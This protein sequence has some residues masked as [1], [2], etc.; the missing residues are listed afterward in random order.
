MAKIAAAAVVLGLL[1]GVATV[2]LRRQPAPAPATSAMTVATAPRL[3]QPVAASMVGLRIAAPGAPSSEAAGL[4]VDGGGLVVT[5][6]LIPVGASVTILTEDHRSLA[7]SVQ[8]SD[9]I[10]GLSLLR[11]E[12]ELPAPAV[13]AAAPQGT[14][15]ATEVWLSS[16][17]SGVERITWSATTL[18]TPD[19]PVVVDQVGLGTMTDASSGATM[20]GS[21]LVA[22]DGSLLGIAAPELGLHHWLPAA[23][24]ESLASSTVAMSSHGCLKIEGRTSAGGV[25]VLSVEPNGPAAGLLEPGDVVTGI[26]TSQLRTISEL[27]DD[28]YA[29]AP[30]T[31]VELDVERGGAVVHVGV[32]LASST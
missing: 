10:A 16:S 22:P 5:T 17:P 32:S 4:I 1:G 9:P 19:A 26:G 21:A 8:A 2:A 25:E 28:L 24:V 3:I 20:A 30:G 7:A 29:T 27:L 6:A 23:L 15:S 14:H 12:G 31:S 18:S 11:T 13:T